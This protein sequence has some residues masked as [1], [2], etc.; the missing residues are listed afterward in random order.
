MPTLT[1]GAA[2]EL[3]FYTRTEIDGFA[4]RLEVQFSEGSSAD[5][6]GYTTLLLSV[7]DPDACPSLDWQAFSAF[8]PNVAEGRFAFRNSVAESN[9][10][11]YIDT[12]RVSRPDLPEPDAATLS[13]GALALLLTS[14]RPMLGPERE[15]AVCF[16]YSHSRCAAS[17]PTSIVARTISR[18]MTSPATSHT[19]SIPDPGASSRSIA[20]A[21]AATTSMCSV[22][23]CHG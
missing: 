8:L 16:S 23:P 9:T 13:A 7:D 19:S 22:K 10:A 6:S 1:L 14:A 3:S 2:L 11:N 21:S 4:D 5:T 17:A 20:T 15:H 12:A 18:P